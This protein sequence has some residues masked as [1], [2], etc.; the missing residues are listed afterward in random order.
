MYADFKVLIRWSV[1]ISVNKFLVEHQFFIS[2]Y[3]FTAHIPLVQVPENNFLFTVNM[4]D[5]TSG[6]VWTLF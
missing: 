6:E 2:Y 3:I 4:R 1:W 5:R